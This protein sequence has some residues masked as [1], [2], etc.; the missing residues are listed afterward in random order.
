[1]ANRKAVELVVV[2]D[3]TAEE[4]EDSDV[5]GRSAALEAADDMLG[6]LDAKR[7]EARRDKVTA[8]RHRAE[9]L[10]RQRDAVKA[11]A[12]AAGGSMPH[13]KEPGRG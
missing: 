6:P 4:G 3:R 2:A 5:R 9:A 8:Q 12:E 1:M 7:T 13:G 11:L 10:T